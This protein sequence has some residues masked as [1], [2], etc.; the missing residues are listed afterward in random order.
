MDEEAIEKYCEGCH[1]I[2][3]HSE[4]WGINGDGEDDVCCICDN[5]G[6]TSYSK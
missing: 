5:C 6:S 2:T 1:Q 3:L 4:F